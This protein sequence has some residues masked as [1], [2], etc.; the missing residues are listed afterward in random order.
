VQNARSPA[1]AS[2]I[3][4]TSRSHAARCSAWISSS[5]VRPRKAFIFCGRLIVIHWAPP[6]RSTIRSS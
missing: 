6:R 3:A 1:P 5:Q 2:T 4:P